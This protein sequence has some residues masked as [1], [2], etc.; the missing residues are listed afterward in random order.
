MCETTRRTTILILNQG[1][2]I[3]EAC[4]AMRSESQA[5][6]RSVTASRRRSDCRLPSSIATTPS[7]RRWA[8]QLAATSCS[9]SAKHMEKKHP[10]TYS[11]KS[12]P[13]RAY[14]NRRSSRWSPWLEAH[15]RGEPPAAGKQWRLSESFGEAPPTTNPGRFIQLFKPDPRRAVSDAPARSDHMDHTPFRF[16]FSKSTR[17][18]R[19]PFGGDH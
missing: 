17:L 14:A 11:T 3:H 18:Q 12:A 13:R 16:L 19:A 5:E 2:A 8:S 7:P 6:P 10:T 1:A 15:N 9:C 4:L